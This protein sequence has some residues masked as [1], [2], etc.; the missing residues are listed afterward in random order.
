MVTRRRSMQKWTALSF[1]AL[2]LA[3]VAGVLVPRPGQPPAPPAPLRDAGADALE[4]APADASEP[5]PTQPEGDASVPESVSSTTDAGGTL[6][7]GSAPPALPPDAPKSVVFGVV[8]VQYRGAQG[9]PPNAPPRE[10]AL[11]TARQL[12]ETAK[13]DFRAAVSKGDKGSMENAGRLARGFIEPAPEYVLFSLPKD[14]VSE[15]VDTP[16]GFWIVRRIE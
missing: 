14:G 6:L 1:A 13:R 12:A 3:F 16:R 4:A 5:A 15:P 2:L 9:A 7:N 8:L 11:E 10:T